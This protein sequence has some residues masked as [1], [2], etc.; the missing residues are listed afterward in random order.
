MKTAYF[1]RFS[2]D[3][4][5]DCAADCYTPGVDA[6]EPVAYWAKRLT[7]DID[8]KTLAA[9]LQEYG[10]WDSE[11]LADHEDNIERIIW[12][13]ACDIAENEGGEHA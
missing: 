13:A 3:L 5:D 7:L 10:A 9:E 8:P 4:P 2:I 6:A 1:N 12:I 11:E